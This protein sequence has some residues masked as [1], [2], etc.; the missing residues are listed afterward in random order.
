M[1]ARALNALLY[2][3]SRYSET[4]GSP[5][6]AAASAPVLCRKIALRE[7]KANQLASTAASDISGI[8]DLGMCCHSHQSGNGLFFSMEHL[9]L[10]LV[11]WEMRAWIR[12]ACWIKFGVGN[13]MLQI[14]IFCPAKADDAGGH[15]DL[16]G[17]ER[18]R[19][20]LAVDN[21]NPKRPVVHKLLPVVDIGVALAVL[22]MESG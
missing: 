16:P 9:P 6:L 21:F 15:G 22:D 8:N 13:N 7:G 20:F 19:R 3:C 4:T 10:Q 17:R 2:R 18:V 12:P 5:S 1:N 11:P 14:G